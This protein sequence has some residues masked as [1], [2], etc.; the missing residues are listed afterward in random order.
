MGP[1]IISG[2]GKRFLLPL[3]KAVT[4]K[5][6]HR[7]EPRRLGFFLLSLVLANAAQATRHPDDE[8]SSTIYFPGS[9]SENRRSSYTIELL[10]LALAKSG[11]QYHAK[12]SDTISP[13]A[14]DFTLLEREQGIDIVWSMTQQER[15]D[16]FL[17]IRIPIFKG[18]S[19]WRIPLVHRDNRHVLASVDS[20]EQL[21]AIPVGQVYAWTDTKILHHNGFNVDSGPTHESM[22]RM[23]TAKRFTYF[24]HSTL[25]AVKEFQIHKDN[26][27]VI[28]KHVAVYYPTA[29]YFFVNKNNRALADSIEEGLETAIADGTF[30]QLFYQHHGDSLELAAIPRR[31]VFRLPNPF[32]P[33]NTPTQR[34]ELWLDPE[35]AL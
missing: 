1:R 35:Y 14:R 5:I 17:A 34:A 6:V 19:G 30:D 18:L 24:L 3:V 7:I 10:Q 12:P 31:R 4:S 9:A 26:Q 29:I 20:L 15:E 33:S 32:L 23:L 11:G 8:R 16:G 25:E 27:I 28:D 22:F 13:K 21:K 2:D